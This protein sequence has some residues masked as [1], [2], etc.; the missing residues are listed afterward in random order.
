MP[1]HKIFNERPECQD[2]L[3]KF[4]EKM[5]YEYVSRSEAEIKRGSLSKVLFDDEL[6][7][8]LKKQ[9]Y[10]FKGY[11]LLFSG[12]SISKAV[13]ALDASLLQG[14]SMASKEIYNLLTLGISLEES[15]ALDKDMPVR[16]SFD[17][18]YIDFEHPANN[19]WQ[20]TEEFSVE[21]PNGQYA[22][23]D[24]VIMVNGIPLAVIECKKSSID[25]KEG[26]LQNVRNMMPDYIPQL[27]KYSQLV[28]ALSPNKI[29]YGTAGTTADYFVEWREDNITWQKE[30]CEKCSPD[31]QILEQDRIVVSLLDK[32]RILDLTQN[33]ILYDSNIKK[34]ARHQQFFAIH[35]AI[36]RINGKDG[37]DSR[38]GVI[39]HTQGS[40]KSLTMVMLVKKIQMDKSKENPRF[41]IV[42]D[43]VNLDKQIRDNFANSQM[44]PVRAGTGKG[45]KTLLK[46]KSNIVITTL[47]NKFEIVCKNRYLETDSD[48][49]YVL[50]DEAHR[51]QYSSMYNYM[52]EVL[53]NATVLAFTGTPLISKAKRNTYKKFGDPIHNYTMKRSIDDRITVPLVYEGRKV[54]QNDP[55]DTIDAYFESLT[56]NLPDEQKKKLKVKYSRFSKL[57]EAS[58]RINLIAFDIY[59]HFTNYCLPK[60]L[61]AMVVCASRGA[62]VDIYNVL[63]TMQ[64]VIPRVVITF[65]DK[66]EGDDDDN[67]S[68]AIKKIK[69]YH[70]KMVK[71]LFGDNDEK[72]DDSVC[73]DFKN[74]EGDINILIVKDKLLTGFDAPIAGVLYI[75]KSIQ[76]HSLLQAIARINRVFKGKDFGLIVDY[77]GVFGKLNAAIDMYNDSE[78]G[79]NQF[80][81]N[82]ITDAIYGPIDEKNKLEEAHR[83]LWDMFRSLSKN[84]TPN[85]WQKFLEDDQL[86]KEFYD[87]LK[88][89]ANILNLA[90]TSREIFVEVGIDLIEKYKA[91]YLFFK[92]LKDS[93]IRRYDD[94]LDYSKY[95]E[96]IKNLIDT[97]VNATDIK[98]IVAPVSIGDE[99]AMS[100]LLAQMDSNEARGDAIKTR[101]ES[102]LKQVRYDDPLLYEE[103]STKIKETLAEYNATREADKYYVVME[104]MA[105]DF[106]NGIVSQ[107]YPVSIANDSDTKAFY[108]SI[109]TILRNKTD[110]EGSVQLEEKIAEYALNI[111]KAVA[112]NAKRDWKHNEIVHKAIHRMLDDC[113]FEMFDEIG[114]VIDNSNVDMIDLIIDEIM[115]VAVAR[116]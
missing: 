54:K 24:V 97:F 81:S 98:T 30:I 70:T 61:K 4:L 29:L 51:S 42:T 13:N 18:N 113:L 84:A 33:F 76:E 95:E 77:W 74:P 32:K 45:L 111:K 25:I 31:G 5:G 35:N 86:R 41:V 19:I 37:K 110:V 56:Q 73:D 58:S 17:L 16:Q 47:I 43:R 34:I 89:Y 64:G 114:V 108:G 3:I 109:V 96:G 36:D 67:T 91:N 115:K 103:F 23:P 116:Y 60:G 68:S 92:K 53:P 10:K 93:V 49:F 38:G 106:R 52:R 59:D 75:D 46:D 44:A 7:R 71:P 62:A 105:D 11:E 27:F 94:S 78:S 100:Q 79:F 107:D 57:A 88:T 26:V 104:R 8:F 112:N 85:E 99:K 83:T 22:R 21:K 63:N 101:I 55:S 1:N 9:H 80:D 14:L 48:N 90:L 82:D 12:E 72:Y 65:G 15:I 6:I 2:R 66:R 87:K 39:W 50:I 28:L 102:K 40:G 20:V 69:D